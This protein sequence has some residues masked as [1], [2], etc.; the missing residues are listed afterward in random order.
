MELRKGKQS[1]HRTVWR[2]SR[3]SPNSVS[4]SLFQFVFF[5]NTCHYCS[6]LSL[7]EQIR[8]LERV[9]LCLNIDGL[10][11]NVDDNKNNISLRSQVRGYL[12]KWR[13]DGW[14][15]LVNIGGGMVRLLFYLPFP[16]YE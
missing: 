3:L 14:L 6:N 13:E 9:A 2:F 5:F 10:I 15:L 12:T 8:V 7:V 16:L 4:K 11:K 1:Y